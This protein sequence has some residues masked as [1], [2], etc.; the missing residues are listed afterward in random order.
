MPCSA[1]FLTSGLSFSFLIR[2]LRASGHPGLAEVHQEVDQGDL[3]EGISWGARE[4]RRLSRTPAGRG[5]GRGRRPRPGGRWVGV[6]V[7]GLEER[8]QGPAPGR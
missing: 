4:A 3:D 6:G 7:E 2:A 1:S 5:R 8:V